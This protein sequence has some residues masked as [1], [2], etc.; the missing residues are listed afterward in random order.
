MQGFSI[1]LVSHTMKWCGEPKKKS[2][3]SCEET[4]L[5]SDVAGNHVS[6]GCPKPPPYLVALSDG[7][8]PERLR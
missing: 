2:I 8:D 6:S 1:L 4:V 7:S 5:Q 3:V